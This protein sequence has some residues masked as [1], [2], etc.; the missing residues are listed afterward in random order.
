MPILTLFFFSRGFN[1]A[2]NGF[3]DDSWTLLSSSSHDDITIAARPTQKRSNSSLPL[4]SDGPGP[5]G[6]G[7]VCVKTTLV[8]QVSFFCPL[9]PSSL[10]FP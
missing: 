4:I 8:L 9:L 5:I 6:G 7:V 10:G 2:I 3:A 1:E